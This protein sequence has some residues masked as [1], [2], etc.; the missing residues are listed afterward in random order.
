MSYA[1]ETY[2]VVITVDVSWPDRQDLGV[3]RDAIKGLTLEHA[4]G[5]AEANWPMALVE[6]VGLGDLT[7]DV[8]R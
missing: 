1:T 8:L 2:P 5:R 3:H 4:L 7:E 6:F